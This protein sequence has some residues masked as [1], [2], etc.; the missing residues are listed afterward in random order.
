MRDARNRGGAL[1]ATAVPRADDGEAQQIEAHRA[2]PQLA[3]T[4]R[5]IEETR[6]AARSAFRNWA[7][8]RRQLQKA[9]RWLFFLD[10]DGTLVDLR[11]RPGD[12]RMSRAAKLVLR[13][14][15]AHSQTQV[16]IVSGRTRRN[17]RDLIG[18][19][20]LRYFGVH[21]GEREG[22]SVTLSAKSR[23]A[24]D[25]VKRGARRRLKSIP[26][27]W[28]QDKGLS[29]AIHYRDADTV[30]ARTARATLED[31]LEPWK[32]AL[33]LL[34]GSRVWEILPREIPGKFTVVDD[35]LGVN[36]SGSAVVY[37]GNDGTDEVAFAAL[38][39]AITVRV[40]RE[41]ETRARYFVRTPSE[42]LRLLARMERELP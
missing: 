38:P 37:I 34:N 20:D 18:V 3:V 28:I 26:G 35:V 31:L 1:R 17:V 30:E 33:H 27:V 11:P 7:S 19:N 39:D 13:R 23:I 36:R 5:K 24:L 21:G 22:Q 6:A 4:V 9:T 16:V 40:G 12:V 14:L 8:I 2:G 41:P 25:G 15:A 10:F 32:G 29:I 42:V